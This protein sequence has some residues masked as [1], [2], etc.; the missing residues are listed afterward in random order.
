[1]CGRG[2]LLPLSFFYLRSA[3]CVRPSVSFM[4]LCLVDYQMPACV[5]LCL[6]EP[7]C[8]YL[9]FLKVCTCLSRRR[10]FLSILI[11]CIFVAVVWQVLMISGCEDDQ[12]SADV[13]DVSQFGLRKCP[14]CH[15]RRWEIVLQ[16]FFTHRHRAR[17]MFGASLT[18]GPVSVHA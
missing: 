11:L 14:R 9:S 8:L 12:T 1:M 4:W 18:F 2:K 10:F 6:L 16:K 15:L 3:L 17:K 5:Y 13:W 7:I